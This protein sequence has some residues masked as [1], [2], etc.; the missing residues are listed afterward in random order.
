MK[1]E[2]LGKEDKFLAIGRGTQGFKLRKSNVS[3]SEQFTVV[4][5]RL[6]LF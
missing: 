5:S 4:I 2:V 1:T 6:S 3:Y